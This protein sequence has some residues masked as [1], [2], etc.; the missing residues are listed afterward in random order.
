MTANYQIIYPIILLS[1]DMMK[2]PPTIG[3]K[4]VMVKVIKGHVLTELNATTRITDWLDGQNQR[5]WNGTITKPYSLEFMAGYNATY[6]TL[7]YEID[8][9]NLAQKLSQP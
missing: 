5:I 4:D 7:P 1:V 8:P 3:R 2:L 6:G 9:E